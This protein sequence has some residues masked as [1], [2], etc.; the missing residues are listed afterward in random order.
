MEKSLL[1]L[2]LKLFNLVYGRHL[3]S[4]SVCKISVSLVAWSL[5]IST[6]CAKTS[7]Q[8][9]NGDLNGI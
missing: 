3:L 9:T 6:N 1:C 8:T 4:E 7:A 2:L 5:S